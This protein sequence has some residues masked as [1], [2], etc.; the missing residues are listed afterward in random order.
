MPRAKKATESGSLRQNL[1][2]VGRVKGEKLESLKRALAAVDFKQRGD[3]SGFDA[4]YVTDLERVFAKRYRIPMDAIYKQSDFALF[5]NS[6]GEE[7]ASFHASLSELVMQAQLEPASSRE[8]FCFSGYYAALHDDQHIGYLGQLML[9]GQN[10]GHRLYS[11][12]SK[13]FITPVPGDIVVLN[14]RERHALVPK[15]GLT[16]KECQA[17]PLLFFALPFYGKSESA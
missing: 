14:T 8:G 13:T 9:I 5:V 6:A 7:F 4:E 16:V 3:G 2:I 10:A 15:R 12:P 1:E 17:E 11:E